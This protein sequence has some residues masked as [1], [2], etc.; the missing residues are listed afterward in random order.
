MKTKI[1]LGSCI[2]IMIIAIQACHSASICSKLKRGDG[3]NSECEGCECFELATIGGGIV[4]GTFDAKSQGL[5]SA[6]VIRS[7]ST[8]AYFERD[9]LLWSRTFRVYTRPSRGIK[10]EIT[11]IDLGFNNP[12]QV[13]VYRGRDSIVIF[14]EGAIDDSPLTFIRQ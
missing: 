3:A 13:F 14:H 11:V 12:E 7:D 1:K 9:S 5:F 2:L 8:L 10:G 4:G 6:I